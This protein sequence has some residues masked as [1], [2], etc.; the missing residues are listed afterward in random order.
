V[1]FDNGYYNMSLSDKGSNYYNSSWNNVKY[2]MCVHKDKSENIVCANSD[3]GDYQLVTLTGNLRF[4]LEEADNTPFTGDHFYEVLDQQTGE[5]N[6]YKDSACTQLWINDTN[7]SDFLNATLRIQK[8]KTH[9]TTISSSSNHTR[10][11]T[12]AGSTTKD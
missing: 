9:C 12:Y 11:L 2:T 8:H 6:F 3:N 5:T 10:E 1:Y 7:D 4:K